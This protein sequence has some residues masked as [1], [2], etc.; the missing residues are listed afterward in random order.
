VRIAGVL[1]SV[2][3]PASWSAP[4]PCPPFG[5]CHDEPQCRHV[6]ID[7]GSR[8]KGATVTFA[9]RVPNEE[10]T[11]STVRLDVQFPTDHPIANVLVQEKPGWTFTTQTRSLAMPIKT[12]DGTFSTAVSEIS[13]ASAGSQ[14]TPGGF[15]L[16]TVFAGPL[17]K[18]TNQL[19]FKAVQTYRNGDVVR[20][21][22]LPTRGAPPPD[23]PAPVMRLTKATSS[24]G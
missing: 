22:E 17:P 13:W 16:F 1:T 8:P 3:G 19:T 12:D 2:A 23:H 9:F 21:I 4:A 15:D 18:N 20:W 7:P 10:D 11:A 5:R 14:I 24:G 6:E